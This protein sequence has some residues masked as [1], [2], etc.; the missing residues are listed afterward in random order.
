MWSKVDG[1]DGHC[2][3]VVTDINS[4]SSIAELCEFP[5]RGNEVDNK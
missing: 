3:V 1:G 5:Y 4:V 2:R